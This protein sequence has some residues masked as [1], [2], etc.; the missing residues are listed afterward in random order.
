MIESTWLK[1]RFVQPKILAAIYAFTI[2][3][4]LF[5]TFASLSDIVHQYAQRNSSV[6]MLENLRTRTRALSK[7]GG[8]IEPDLPFLDGSSATIASALLLQ[9]VTSAISGSHGRILL[10]EVGHRSA[11]AKNGELK[12]TVNFQIDQLNLQRLLYDLESSVPFLFVKQLDIQ[13]KQPSGSAAPR[14]DVVMQV[15][16]IWRGPK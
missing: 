12:T 15:T 6:A 10:S 9:R 16:G 7:H 11:R 3:F 1:A 14:L 8:K 13:A 2:V 5:L 4:L